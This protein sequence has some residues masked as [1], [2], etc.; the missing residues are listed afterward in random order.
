MDMVDCGYYATRYIYT[1][2]V[3]TNMEVLPPLHIIVANQ[4]L[5]VHKMFRREK[6]GREGNRKGKER[7]EGGGGRGERGKGKSD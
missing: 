7:C 1:G 2:C 4:P 3:H 5:G 6:E